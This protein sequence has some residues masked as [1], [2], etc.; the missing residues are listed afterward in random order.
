MKLY[1]AG[2]MRGRPQFNFPAFDA[3]AAQLRGLGHYVF[4]PAEVDRVTYGDDL[5]DAAHNGDETT[6]A[7]S[8]GFDLRRALGGDLAFIAGEADGVAVLPGWRDSKGA[9]AEVATALALGLV[10]APFDAFVAA[11]EHDLGVELDARITDLDPALD[12]VVAD[13]TDALFGEVRS[14]S[15]TGGE[16]GV[17]PQRFDLLPWHS[18]GVVAEHYAKGAEKY[19][20]HNWRRGYEWSKSF[21]ALQRHLSAWWQG[22][23]VDAETGSSHLAA[24]AFHVLALI[25]FTRDFPQFDDRYQPETENDQ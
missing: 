25:E 24:A 10:V 7:A 3:A 18:L 5:A 21:A 8:H 22:E 11:W 1:V 17:K 19:A 6:V 15:V 16:K 4:N 2:P 20:A 23:D 9:R 13:T 12:V 14:V